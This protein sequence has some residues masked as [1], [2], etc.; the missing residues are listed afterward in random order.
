VLVERTKQ[1]H[2]AFVRFREAFMTHLILRGA[3]ELTA[4]SLFVA[5]IGLWAGIAAG[6]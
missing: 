2:T 3:A 5:M 4:L 1:E 6:A